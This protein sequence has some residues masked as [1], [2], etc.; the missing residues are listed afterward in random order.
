[1]SL[2]SALASSLGI[3]TLDIGS[4]GDAHAAITALD[5]AIN[6]VSA[7]RANLGAVQN[8]LQGTIAATENRIAALRAM[9]AEFSGRDRGSA[10]PVTE[11]AGPG[12]W[13]VRPRGPWE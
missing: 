7:N 12:P 5:S 1:M 10:A 9:E 11:F 13:E 6:V 8:T 4:T 2:S 3:D